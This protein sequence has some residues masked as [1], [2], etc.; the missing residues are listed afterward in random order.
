VR[1]FLLASG[2]GELNMKV[3]LKCLALI[4][5]FSTNGAAR[6]ATVTETY[7]FN[8]GGFVDVVGSAPSPI[9]SISGSFTVTFDPT[10]A[11]DN[12]TAGVSLTSSLAPTI[13]LGSP[14]GL[15]VV[16]PA[17]ASTPLVF[18]VGGIANDADFLA[19]IAMISPWV[20]CF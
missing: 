14:V 7:N 9:S 18:F 3:R 12:Q 2:V 13:S 17:S 20:W 8:L 15:T 5:V 1:C 16:V 19:P 4:L 10:V 11:V 6:A